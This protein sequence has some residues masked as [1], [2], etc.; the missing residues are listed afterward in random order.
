MKTRN[1]RDGSHTENKEN[2]CTYSFCDA[3]DVVEKKSMVWLVRTYIYSPKRHKQYLLALNTYVAA[4][5]Q[6][7]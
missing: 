1:F 7:I 6:E 4:E 2:K 3:L 5:F